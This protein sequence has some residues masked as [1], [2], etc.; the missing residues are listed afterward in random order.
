MTPDAALARS[1]ASK[2]TGVPPVSIRRFETGSR[3]HVFDLTFTDHAPLVVRIGDRSAHAEMA[4]AVTLS[5]L[6]RPLGVP[7]PQ[8]LAFDLDAVLPW[9]ALERLPGRDLGAAMSGLSER[10]LDAIAAGVARAQAIT[11][12]TGASVRYGYAVQPKA[13]PFARWSDVLDA[14]LARSRQRI[15][16]ADLFDPSL[17]ATAEA[18]LTVLRAEANAIPATPLLHDTTTR[19]VIVAPDG[20]LSGIVDVDDL[21]FGDPRLPAALTRA[22]LLAYGGPSGYVV[23]WLRH[24]GQ[25][26]DRLFR[27]YVGM[28]LLDLMS[29]HGQTFNGNQQPSR[30]E[31]RTAL[32]RAFTGH[33]DGSSR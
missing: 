14:N 30:P 2:L 16:A 12:A 9:L 18:E 23:A 25:A 15:A 33:H 26:D 20:S 32:L 22:V 4:S 29:E 8:L 19:N 1:I 13:A 3:H 21:C 28:F 10:Q 17:V 11:A 6:L 24:A 7:L 5:R 31:A 27:L